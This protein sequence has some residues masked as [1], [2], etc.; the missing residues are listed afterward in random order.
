[1]RGINATVFPPNLCKKRNLIIKEHF[2]SSG[3]ADTIKHVI[4]AYSFKVK[5][6]VNS[7]SPTKPVLQLLKRKKRQVF[8]VILSVDK[9]VILDI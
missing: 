9:H 6:K 5:R 8:C 7:T 1:M 2:V 4:N 3:V